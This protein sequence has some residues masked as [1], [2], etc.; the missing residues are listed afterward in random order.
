MFEA[1]C[2]MIFTVPENASIGRAILVENEAD[3]SVH[4]PLLI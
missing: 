2:I 4:A 3:K 1:E